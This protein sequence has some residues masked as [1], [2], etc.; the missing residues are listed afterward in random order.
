MNLL[1]TGFALYGTYYWP[2]ET[3]G[4]PFRVHVDGTVQPARPPERT[5]VPSGLL[6]QSPTLKDGEHVVNITNVLEGADGGLRIAALD[7]AVMTPSLTT[8]LADEVLMV[9]DSH[10]NVV[11]KGAGW[12]TLGNEWNSVYPAFQNTTH[13]TSSTGDSFEFAFNGSFSAL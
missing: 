5:S 10:P 12:K 8:S 11:F 1:G 4:L 6:Y 7:Y 13:L 9:A 3:P 2:A